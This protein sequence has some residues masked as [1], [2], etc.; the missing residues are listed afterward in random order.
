MEVRSGSSRFVG[1]FCL[2]PARYS[3]HGGLALN[4]N[5]LPTRHTNILIYPVWNL[6]ESNGVVYIFALDYFDFAGGG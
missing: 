2:V 5:L 4:V 6:L 1:A 3:Q